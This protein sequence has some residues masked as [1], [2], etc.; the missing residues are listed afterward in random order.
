MIQE[1]NLIVKFLWFSDDSNSIEIPILE[2]I[3]DLFKGKVLKLF[4]EKLFIRKRLNVVHAIRQC[5]ATPAL[6]SHLLDCHKRAL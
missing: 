5:A 6:G 3:L 1:S 4:L 2:Y